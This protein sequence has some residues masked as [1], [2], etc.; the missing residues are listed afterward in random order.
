MRDTLSIV[1]IGLALTASVLGFFLIFNP[2]TSFDRGESLEFPPDELAMRVRQAFPDAVIVSTRLYESDKMAYYFVRLRSASKERLVI[3]SANFRSLS[4]LQQTS[5][6]VEM[7]SDLS[8]SEVCFLVIVSCSCLTLTTFVGIASSRQF[9]KRASWFLWWAIA[10]LVIVVTCSL[11]LSRRS[12]DVLLVGLMAIVFGCSSAM[13]S[14]AIASATL[15]IRTLKA[16][17]FYDATVFGLGLAASLTL[18]VPLQ[19][20]SISR[21]NSYYGMAVALEGRRGDNKH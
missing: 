18:T 19:T 9:S 6:A 21:D 4:E 8:W 10:L 20:I 7:L 11:L 2:T 3:V 16:A 13:L 15:C 14:G 5:S 12:N 1:S 17:A